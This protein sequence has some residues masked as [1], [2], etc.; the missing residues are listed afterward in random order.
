MHVLWNCYIFSGLRLMYYFF[1]ICTISFLNT[2]LHRPNIN[3]I[4]F[5]I[6][7]ASVTTTQNLSITTNTLC[8]PPPTVILSHGRNYLYRLIHLEAL[9]QGVLTS[10]YNL[11]N[12]F[13]EQKPSTFLN[14]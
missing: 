5:N 7:R 13:L 11:Y 2:C 4:I 6:V 8:R 1:Y 12:F 3:V 14:H 9:P 10:P